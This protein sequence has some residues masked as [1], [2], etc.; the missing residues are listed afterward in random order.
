MAKSLI[1]VESPTKA[2]TIKKYLGDDYE[3]K[4]SSGHVVDLPVGTLGVDVEKD[5]APKYVVI[6]DKRKYIEALR[7]AAKDAEKVYLASD[8]DREGEAIAWHIA[9]LLKLGEKAHRILFHEITEKAIREAIQHP[10]ELSREKFEAQQARRILDRLVGYNLSPILWKKV[11]KG[12][13]AGRVQSVALRLVVDREREIEEFVPREYWTIQARLAKDGAAQEGEFTAKLV[14]F[15]G[16]KVDLKTEEE[17]A[18]V[19]AAVE[20]EKFLV[21]KVERKERRR[22]PPAPFITSTLQQE[23]YRKLRFPVKKTMALAQKLYEGVELGD[24]GPV[25]LIT[26][27]RTDSVRVSAEVVREAR[28]YI[29]DHFDSAYLPPRPNIYKTKKSA[30]DAHEAI[31]PTS[32][33]YTPAYVRNHLSPDEYKLYE[34][35][36]NRFMASQMAPA[37]YD[38]TVVEIEA[39]KGLF[40]AT[41]S[42][43]KFNGFTVL[44]TESSDETKTDGRARDDGEEQSTPLPPLA[45][46]D[47]LRVLGVEKSQ[48]FTQPPPR[49][50]ESTLIKELEEKGIGRPSTY[51]TILSTLLDRGYVIKSK[52]KLRPTLLG[53][54]VAELLNEGFPEIMDVQFTAY[55]E[56]NLDRVEEGKINWVDVLR[57]FYEGF[58]RR[59]KGAEQELKSLR[60]EGVPTDISCDQ[61]G[62]PMIIKWGRKGEFLSCSNFP[63]CKNAKWF[64]VTPE[65]EIVVLPRRESV[66]TDLTCEKCG[67]PMVIK[68]SKR[69]DEFLACSNYPACKNSKQFRYSKDGKVEVVERKAE[70][71]E[72]VRCDL[73]GSPMALRAGRY[74][75]FFGCTAYPKCRGTKKL[76]QVDK[77]IA[78]AVEGGADA[79]EGG[80]VASS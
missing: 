13:S 16:S 34:L 50:S 55:M 43:L 53:R 33:H 29:R 57:E 37:V 51:A 9:R 18:R 48:H 27:M 72:D 76:T 78:S 19:L 67:S 69:G 75:K 62:A 21:R 23:A 1:I 2:N 26:Y 63:A 61:C 31:R 12:L 74:G 17:A 30:Q 15:D 38:R 7:R 41:G 64:K 25:G 60:R 79:S 73:C 32:V 66:E 5:F 8:P 36:W 49:F 80:G 44:Y 22:R 14:T 39:G 68:I 28:Q 35:I 77:E 10:Q 40:R 56:E 6:K 3:V 4:A 52:G 42:V 58:A 70:V 46:G 65:G 24:A 47:V 20:G 59:L 45:E 54:S 71:Y 11:R